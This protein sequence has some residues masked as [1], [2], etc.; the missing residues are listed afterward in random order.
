MTEEEIKN[1]VLLA[2]LIKI[3]ETKYLD[4]SLVHVLKEINSKLNAIH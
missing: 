3:S 1:I 2:K 4:E